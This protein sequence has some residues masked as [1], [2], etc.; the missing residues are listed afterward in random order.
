MKNFPCFESLLRALIEIVQVDSY[1]SSYS[2]ENH[3]ILYFETDLTIIHLNILFKYEVFLDISVP[4]Q[5]MEQILM[6]SLLVEGLLAWQQ[7][8]S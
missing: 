8:G 5:R 2:K 4:H 6:W 7:P 3:I 1:C